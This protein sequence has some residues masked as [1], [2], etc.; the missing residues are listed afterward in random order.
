MSQSGS[1]SEPP[2]ELVVTE[3][4][5]VRF[6]FAAPPAG[7]PEPP[8]KEDL[9]TLAD[10][11]AVIVDGKWLI[12]L[13]AAVA[14]AIGV[15]YALLAT[16]V[17]RT[18][19]LVQV[20]EKSSGG[21]DQLS[22]LFSETS[23]MGAEIEILRSRALVGSVVDELNLDVVVA[24]GYLPVVGRAIASWRAGPEPA[25]ALLGL[26]RN[27]WG[28]ERITVQHLEVPPDLEGEELTL[29]AG[30]QG[31]FTVEGPE[32]E[33]LLSGEVGRTSRTGPGE[34]D[35]VGVFVAE[36][37]ARPGTEFR[38]LKRPRSATIAD[39]RQ[40]LS[41]TETGKKSGILKLELN[42]T[43]RKRAAATLDALTRA[44]LRQNVERKSAEAQKTLEFL[45]TQLP[46]LKANVDAAESA[47]NVHRSRNGSVDLSLETQGR[48]ARAVEV[49][50]LLSELEVQRA[51]LRQRFTESHPVLI[52]VRQ[53]MAQ[54][55]GE[56]STIE[57]KIKELPRAE[58]EA[59]RLTRDVKVANELYVLLLN[60]AQELRVVKSGTIGNVRIVDAA[61]LPDTPVSP[62]K[63]LSMIGALVLGVGLGVI[64]A[65]ARRALD[66]GVEDPDL[67]EQRFGMGVYASV[68]HSRRQAE[69][70]RSARRMKAKAVT[71]LAAADPSDVAVES[72]R[73]LRTS[74][75]F[76][77]VETPSRVI[78]I[79]GPSPGVGKSFVTLN[80]AGVLADTGKRILVV[81]GDMRKGRLHRQFGFERSPGLSELISGSVSVDEAVRPTLA[82]N[83]SLLPTGRVPPN[84]SELL[85][86]ERF[87]NAVAEL[88]S[89]YDLVLVDTAP[90]LAVTDAMLIGRVADMTLVVLRSGRHPMREIALAVKRLT[91]S[92][93][94]PHGFVLNSVL[95][96]SGTFGSKYTYHYQ[97]DYK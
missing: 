16:P 82:E 21:L 54:L 26:S 88:S 5:P 89:R 62:R 29:V 38:L 84:P 8:A 19:V 78:M 34:R 57:G 42:G 76:A 96:R 56:R 83:I 12:A 55:Q 3:E 64:L 37:V 36:L 95:P 31:R 66:R 2:L 20:E 1:R 67:I 79:G 43:D 33:L 18:D 86:S 59:A 61:V 17:Y 13:T 28:G 68:P 49:E 58:L 9:L 45:E 63:A 46:L 50:K 7:A 30:E 65:F 32:R 22:S 92:G 60:K 74:L 72:L 73:S 53:K 47:L 6:A 15:L 69:L 39:L 70:E 85:A 14:L 40:D 23:P 71:M 27:A 93:V 41:I 94:R 24:P 91:Q 52:A 77:L 44:Y 35:G 97:Y 48:L 4:Q 11:L 51:E 10:V 90:I 80:L 75:E 25:T 81:D 87:R